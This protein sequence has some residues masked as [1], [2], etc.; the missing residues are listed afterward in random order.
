MFIESLRLFFFA[1]LP[2]FLIT[3][4]MF[5]RAILSKRI[6]GFSDQE[7]LKSAIKNMKK[8]YKSEKKGFDF[9]K[10][11][12]QHVID[13][14]LYFGGGFYGLMAF[15]TYMYIEVGQII[16]FFGR[17]FSL[18]LSQLFSSISINML[19]NLFIDAI[20]NLVDAFVWFNF[21]MKEIEM[22]NGWVWLVCTYLAYLAGVKTAQHYPFKYRFSELFKKITANKEA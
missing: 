11:P 22:M 5:S 8:Q 7:S 2:I 16:S 6:E 9:R 17:L 3:H 18:N 15:V 20:M 14:W 10:S 1:F 19:V 21:W 13:K 4:V 12:S